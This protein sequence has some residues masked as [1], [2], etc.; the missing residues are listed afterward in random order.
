[1]K[2]QI[3]INNQINS[4]ELRVI[5]DKAGNLGVLSLT[6]ALKLAEDKGLDLIEI[7]PTATPPV[8]KIMDFGKWQYEEKRK[9][10][11][12]KA[13]SQTTETKSLQIKIATGENDLKLKANKAGKFLRAGHRV[14][15]ELFL[16]GRTKY[17]DK[18]FLHERLNKFLE[19]VPEEYKL[20]E[21]I[22][23]NPKGLYLI[24]EKAKK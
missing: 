17:M 24:I 3:R 11:Q 22:K 12:S 19:M 9:L 2:P 1:M 16:P 10:K 14:K 8:A 18:N 15:L 23:K 7:S 4:P 21:P 6:Q 5:D 20:A 13:K